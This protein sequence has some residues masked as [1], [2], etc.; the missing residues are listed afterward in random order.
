MKMIFAVG[1]LVLLSVPGTGLAQFWQIQAPSLR[2]IHALVRPNQGNYEV[3]AWA[4]AVRELP[5]QA[6]D[7]ILKLEEDRQ[8]VHLVFQSDFGQSNRGF[9]KCPRS[10]AEWPNNYNGCTSRVVKTT[11]DGRRQIFGSTRLFA[12]TRELAQ[13]DVDALA[14]NIG[15]VK[16]A[17]AESRRLAIASLTAESKLGDVDVVAASFSR[18]EFTPEERARLREVTQEIKTRRASR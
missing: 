12:S 2:E 13:Q 8:T 5:Y 9:W 18:D 3:I 11:D 16:K 7:E 1:L 10:R 14:D 6:G 15:F 17:K 4:R